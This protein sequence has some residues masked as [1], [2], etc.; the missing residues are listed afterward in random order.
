MLAFIPLVTLGAYQLG[1]EL[2]L[3]AM[4]VVMPLF[5][6]ALGTF[7]KRPARKSDR[8]P[9]TGLLVR[10][11]LV[12]WAEQSLARPG[13]IHQ[14]VA[15]IA[16]SIDEL[17]GVEV[18]FG[19]Q[20]S[21]RVMREAVNR[22]RS[23]LRDDDIISRLG[24]GLAIGFS[25]LRR[26]ETETLMQLALRLQSVFEDPFSDGPTRTYCSISLGIA[27]QEQVKPA[28]GT[29]LV[30]AAQ[31]ACEL[32]YVSGP[33]AVRFYTEGLSSEVAHEKATAGDLA[34]ALETN[35]IF[36][37][38]QPQ[39]RAEDG[40][41]IGFEALARWDHPERGLISPA[42]FLPDIEKAGLSQRLAEVVLKQSLMALA[43]WDAAGFDVPCISVNFS[44][45]ELRNPRLPDY[46]RWELDRHGIAPE[47][48]VIEVLE[49]V[50]SESSEDVI[51]RTLG[52][53]SRIGCKIDLDD[54]GTGF[55]CFANIRRFDVD[56]IKIDRSLVNQVDQDDTQRAMIAALLAFSDKLGLVT[57]AEG[58][59]TSGEID[60]LKGLGCS[61]IQGYAIARP[62]PLGETFM[63]LEDRAPVA[64]NPVHSVARHI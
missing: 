62:L 58:V 12:D 51:T 55:T 43:A 52:A 42:S 56:R 20:M 30:A 7:E 37:W 45:E 46:I 4:A 19:Q 1:G 50:A 36:A 61:D 24:N 64:A 35:E 28:T 33:G 6:A 40:R 63:W 23:F 16:I 22:L 47:R 14:Q 25:R 29:N 21:D 53:L 49:T 34:N 10:A 54:F 9:L 41:V 13:E 2:S 48:L 15:V 18:R 17:D 57:L 38:F 32:A 27:V 39:V 60:T 5:L 44:G 8:D 59:E 11:G 31:Q 3:I 26:P